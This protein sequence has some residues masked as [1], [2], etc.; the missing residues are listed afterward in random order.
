M[1]A[2]DM[3]AKG[4]VRSG[5]ARF[6]ISCALLFMVIQV[7]SAQQ[8]ADGQGLAPSVAA[9]LTKAKVKSVVVFDFLGPGDK[10]TQLG[11]DLADTF[12][13]SLAKQA[14]QVRVIDRS[15][16]RA[17]IEKNRVAP[18][19]ARESE[20]AWWLARQLKA[21]SLIVGRIEPADGARIHLTLSAAT[22]ERGKNI[23][24]F[25]L[26][27]PV[28]PEMREHF[29]KTLFLTNAATT[30]PPGT[31]F[32]SFPTC[33]HCPRAEFSGAALNQKQDGIVLLVAVVGLDGKLR[34]IDFVQNVPYGLT[35]KSIEAVQTW[36]LDPATDINGK[37]IEV[38]QSISVQFHFARK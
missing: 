31:R 26:D 14:P 19:V 37:P 7:A 8:T 15:E 33:R 2:L 20:L 18:T 16:L 29:V 24:N 28:T 6:F 12:S 3:S 4:V 22:V 36:K 27:I 23:E 10:L 1:R 11:E 13:R 9:A 35:Q 21:Q 25:S 5:C 34:D 38:R 30:P 17:V 32:G